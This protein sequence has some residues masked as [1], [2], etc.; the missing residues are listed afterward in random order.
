MTDW[1]CHITQ[2]TPG[3]HDTFFIIS[4]LN[5]HTRYVLPRLILILSRAMS[6]P[7]QIHI[8]LIFNL[9]SQSIAFERALRWFRCR[10]WEIRQI[11]LLISFLD[12]DMRCYKLQPN[13]NKQPHAENQESTARVCPPTP[14]PHIY[15]HI[16]ICSYTCSN[17][18][19]I[20][21]VTTILSLRFNPKKNV[22]THQAYLNML[23]K[24]D[25][26]ISSS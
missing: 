2:K 23:S 8:P 26:H 20:E 1:R 14:P 12:M 22:S 25:P 5:I 15:I 24:S 13:M 6:R 19:E 18:G 17:R 21:H 16:I 9:T 7:S 11:Y 10:I 4:S 3:Q